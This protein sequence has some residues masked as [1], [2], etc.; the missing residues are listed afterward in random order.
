MSGFS[1][2]SS[3]QVLAQSAFPVPLTGT[4]TETALASIVIP[5]GAMGNNGHVEVE[6]LLSCTN[7]AN[8]K[9]M[10]LKFGATTVFSSNFANQTAGQPRRR[11]ANRNAPASQVTVAATAFPDSG[12]SGAPLTSTEDTAQAV[13]LAITGQLANVADTITLESYLVTLYRA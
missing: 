9:T 8:A 2:R 3:V 6:A 1:Q 13:T 11:I 10:R 12:F 4:L 7:N 5:A